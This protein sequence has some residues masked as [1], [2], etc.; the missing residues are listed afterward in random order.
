MDQEI[1]DPQINSRKEIVIK[2]P[3]LLKLSPKQ[4]PQ[5]GDEK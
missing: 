2:N 4:D 5:V 1:R 3:Y